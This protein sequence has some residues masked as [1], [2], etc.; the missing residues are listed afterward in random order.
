VKL[1]L[2]RP[3][4][5]HSNAEQPFHEMLQYALESLTINEMQLQADIRMAFYQALSNAVKHG[6]NWSRTKPVTLTITITRKQFRLIVEDKGKQNYLYMMVGSTLTLCDKKKAKLL[7]DLVPDQSGRGILRMASLA[8]MVIFS[9]LGHRVTMIFSRP[10][11]GP[12]T[13][14]L[15]ASVTSAVGSA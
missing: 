2:T 1:K 15:P 13:G 14:F 7:L 5:A 10:F 11:S 9:N 4:P 8:D 3:V 12:L 6:N